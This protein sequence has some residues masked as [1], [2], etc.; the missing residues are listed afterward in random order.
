MDIVIILFA[1]IGLVLGLYTVGAGLKSVFKPNPKS[2]SPDEKPVP[3][4]SFRHTVNDVE[5]RF[6]VEKAFKT[7]RN[8]FAMRLKNLQTGETKTV[9]GYDEDEVSFKAKRVF[10]T[11][12]VPS[13]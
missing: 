13:Y 10:G 11:W 1:I 12:I 2:I 6:V 9:Y 7:K 3:W 5:G 4:N 8:H